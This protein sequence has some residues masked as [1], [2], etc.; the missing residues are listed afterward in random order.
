MFKFTLF[1]PPPSLSA[2]IFTSLKVGKS[3]KDCIYTFTQS[4]V[5]VCQNIKNKNFTQMYGILEE[6][7]R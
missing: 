3:W 7:I 2:N 6:D 4:C 1:H 5:P